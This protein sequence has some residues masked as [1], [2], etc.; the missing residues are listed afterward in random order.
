MKI[1]LALVSG[2][3]TPHTCSG[4]RHI[5]VITS[6]NYTILTMTENKISQTLQSL[7][8]AGIAHARGGGRDLLQGTAGGAG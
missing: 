6:R 8:I 3:V 1:V 2:A 7:S 4:K 5:K